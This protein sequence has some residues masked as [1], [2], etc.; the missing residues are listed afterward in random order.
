[1][2]CALCSIPYN[3]AGCIGRAVTIRRCFLSDRKHK[4][5]RGREAKPLGKKGRLI[6]LSLLLAAAGLIVMEQNLS[7]TMLDMA[8]ANAYS[9]AVETVNHAVSQLIDGGITYGELMDTR[10]DSQGQVTMLQAN[11][12]RMNELAA[13]TALLAELEL[14]SYDNQFVEVPL[15]AALGIRF[16][17]GFGPRVSVQ[18]LPVGAVHTS[19]QSEFE[20]AGINQTRHKIL[21]TLRTTV[22]LVVPMGS[23]MVDVNSSIPVAE[24]IIV[25]Q[26][27][28]SF[29][30]VNNEE[31]ML[32][33]IP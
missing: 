28:D 4:H 21:L 9:M 29:V 25:G 23:Q 30:D 17:S 5:S 2:G 18:I 32:N 12:M 27:P 13:K 7:Q 24:S 3:P 6:L 11:T 33:L 14:N 10:L 15:G 1:M 26:V 16:L 22:C 8:Y 31:D 20:S 19:F